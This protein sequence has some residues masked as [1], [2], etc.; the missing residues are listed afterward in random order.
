MLSLLCDIVKVCVL[1]CYNPLIHI[2]FVAMKILHQDIAG[3]MTLSYY[4]WNHKYIIKIELDNYEQT[5]KIQ[6]MDIQDLEEVKKIVQKPHFLD[7][8]FQRFQA[9]DSDLAEALDLGAL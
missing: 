2:N 6:D 9:M 8:V 1:V 7:R 4:H 5:F 3:P